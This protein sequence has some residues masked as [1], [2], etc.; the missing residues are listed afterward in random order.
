MSSR[1]GSLLV[2]T[3][4]LVAIVSMVAIAIA[5]SL[6]L[7]VKL[8]KYRA[9]REQARTLARSGVYLA[10]KRLA[11]EPEPEEYDWLGDDWAYFPTEAPDGD[12]SQWVISCAEGEQVP[13]P[14]G[15]HLRVRIT[16]EERRLPLNTSTIEQLFALTQDQA[17][18]QTIINARDDEEPEQ[19]AE[20]RPDEDPPYFAKD[21]PFAAPEELV[22]LPDMTPDARAN[23]QLHTSPHLTGEAKMNINTMGAEGLSA[24]GLHPTVV[25]KIVEFR[26]GPDGPFEG[27]GTEI[28]DK[29]RE[30]VGGVAFDGGDYVEDQRLL[31]DAFGTS[32]D[33]F[34][35]MVEGVIERPAV[36]VRVEAVVR[37]EGCG[38]EMPAP[39]IIAWRES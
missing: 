38:E 33:T 18:A 21:G 22:D 17:I 2:I 15:S 10:M 27:G 23:L 14:A 7:E 34:T 26:D 29:V 24:V 3:L 31:Q 37:R 20:D 8:A 11:K 32:S 35:V 9:A 25:G 6:S 28:V 4:W 36:R 13:G 30:L 39:C 1:A 19:L 16:D 12:A 5:R